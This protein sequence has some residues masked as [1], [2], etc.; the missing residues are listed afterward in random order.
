MGA[1]RYV[2]PGTD[3]RGFARRR[4]LGRRD[5]VIEHAQWHAY[6]RALALSFDDRQ[7]RHTR[8]VDRRSAARPVFPARREARLFG[9]PA[10]PSR[11]GCR[12]W[13]R[14]L[15]ERARP[16]TAGPRACSIG[17]GLWTAPFYRIELRDGG[18]GEN[19]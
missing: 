6:G 18:R 2:L 5:A 4:R 17:R 1:D 19:I 13:S 11:E 3:A 12:G 8:P 16:A 10:R 15:A 14:T 7:R 9:P